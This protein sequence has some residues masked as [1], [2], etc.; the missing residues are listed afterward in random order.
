[1]YVC[2]RSDLYYT[3]M[4]HFR[5]LHMSTSRNIWCMTRYLTYSKVWNIST[6]EE[7]NTPFN[8]SVINWD[9]F[10]SVKR[11]HLQTSLAHQP[12]LI[13]ELN[14]KCPSL[15]DAICVQFYLILPY[16]V[17]LIAL[18]MFLNYIQ[19]IR[20]VYVNI[21]VSKLI[22]FHSVHAIHVNMSK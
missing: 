14:L 5:R 13:V 21:Q 7:T 15:K 10:A 22:Q 18:F 3:Y 4:L 1:M 6:F 11:C 2:F 9:I 19:A 12:F 16:H 8:K 17:C 20:F